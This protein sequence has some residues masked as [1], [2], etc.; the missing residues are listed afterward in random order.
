MRAQG[1]GISIFLSKKIDGSAHKTFRSLVRLRRILSWSATLCA[2]LGVK[3]DVIHL[4]QFGECIEQ[5]VEI[6]Q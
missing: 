5:V 1:Y 4:N 3:K 6:Q 2:N